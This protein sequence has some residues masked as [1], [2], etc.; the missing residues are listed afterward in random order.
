MHETIVNDR[1]VTVIDPS[2]LMTSVNDA[3]R[4]IPHQH[5][6]NTHGRRMHTYHS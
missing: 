3:S 4:Q 1:E 2:D 5:K 6:D